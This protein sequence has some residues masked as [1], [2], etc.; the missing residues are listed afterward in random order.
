MVLLLLLWLFTVYMYICVE[1]LGMRGRLVNKNRLSIYT[2]V[3]YF[4][5]CNAMCGRVA[6]QRNGAD[7][8]LLLHTTRLLEHKTYHHVK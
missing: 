1:K 3:Y 7:I 8:K 6:F 2:H 5:G 4:L